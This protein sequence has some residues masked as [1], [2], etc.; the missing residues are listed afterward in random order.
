MTYRF[1][2]S[3]D[4]GNATWKD[5]AMAD[6]T[7]DPRTEPGN[8]DVRDALRYV[9]AVEPPVLPPV[10]ASE[11]YE[12]PSEPLALPGHCVVGDGLSECL[13][14]KPN[15]D[16]PPIGGMDRVR[17]ERI[18]GIVE[19][20]RADPLKLPVVEDALGILATDPAL[21]ERLGAIAVKLASSPGLIA[22]VENRIAMGS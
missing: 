13:S 10:F 5:R 22:Q 12:D 1:P 9:A 16:P 19:K 18:S 2:A 20:L 4:A 6:D 11:S 7:Q 14:T 8:A 15:T 3:I 21:R 17:Y